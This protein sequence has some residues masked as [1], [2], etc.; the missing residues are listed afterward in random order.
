[1]MKNP[2]F[3]EWGTHESVKESKKVQLYRRALATLRRWTLTELKLEYSSSADWR[4]RPQVFWLIRSTLSAAVEN[5]CCHTNIHTKLP[6]QDTR[7]NTR[8]NCPIFILERTWRIL[9]LKLLFHITIG[10]E[11]ISVSPENYFP[12][13]YTSTSCHHGI[14]NIIAAGLTYANSGS[15]TVILPN[16]I[17]RTSS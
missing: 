8:N 4:R 10:G 15:H 7:E 12:S 16:K 14:I 13:T 9:T 3:L 11:V 1:M 6:T 5:Q 2:C 17:S